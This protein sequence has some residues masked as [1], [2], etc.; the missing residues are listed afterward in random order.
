MEVWLDI[1]KIQ[2]KKVFN[3]VYVCTYY[4]LYLNDN[5]EGRYESISS[6]NWRLSLILT[7][8]AVY[9]DTTG[10]E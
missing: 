5:Y 2:V 9:T 1:P 6:V 7:E 4:E 10:K 3:E 8:L